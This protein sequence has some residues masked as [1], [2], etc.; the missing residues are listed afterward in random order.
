ML[1]LSF[2]ASSLERSFLALH[3]RIYSA[4]AQCHAGQNSKVSTLI[5]LSPLNPFPVWFIPGEDPDTPGGT[6]F[7]YDSYKMENYPL[8]NCIGS[9]SVTTE[10]RCSG[11]KTLSFICGGKGD[12]LVSQFSVNSL[13]RQCFCEL[14]NLRKVSPL[15]CYSRKLP[16]FFCRCLKTLC[17]QR[18]T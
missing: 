9:V 6:H 5:C 4:T 3:S 16:H 15:L 1:Y 10:M 13:L 2:L 17:S 7:S 8:K 12:A 18:R 11:A 14:E